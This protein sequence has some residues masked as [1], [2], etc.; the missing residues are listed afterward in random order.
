MNISVCK[1]KG[2]TPYTLLSATMGDYTSV[3]EE[4]TP[5]AF[6]DHSVM[7]RREL[8]THQHSWYWRNYSVHINVCN[9]M[10]VGVYKVKSVSLHKPVYTGWRDITFFVCRRVGGDGVTL[11]VLEVAPV[12]RNT[13]LVSFA[14]YWTPPR[15]NRRSV[16][17]IEAKLPYLKLESRISVDMSVHICW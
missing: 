17:G 10:H 5:H 2:I 1:V 11:S 16:I 4:S 13:S 14:A 15:V 9:F 8:C 3:C 6:G 7:G 12:L